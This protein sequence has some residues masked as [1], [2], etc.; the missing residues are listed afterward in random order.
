MKAEAKVA[1]LDLFTAA[2]VTMSSASP[3]TLL[4]TGDGRVAVT[5]DRLQRLYA[6]LP[7]LEYLLEGHPRFKQQAKRVGPVDDGPPNVLELSLHVDFGVSRQDLVLLLGFFSPA[8]RTPETDKDWNRLQT[9]SLL[10]GGSNTVDE[11]FKEKNNKTAPLNPLSP[12][13]D[14][15][16]AFQWRSI[17][18]S[19]IQTVQVI[20]TTREIEEQGF[21]RTSITGAVAYFRKKKEPQYE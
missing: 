7:A 18:P 4:C 3:P 19:Q 6:E 16:E 2:T 20:D 13:M 1:V 21:H 9:V 11:A 17:W 12:V 15:D 10:L 8:Q 14:T 5:Q